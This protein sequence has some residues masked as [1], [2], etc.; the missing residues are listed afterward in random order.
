[1]EISCGVPHESVLGPLLYLIY[2]NDLGNATCRPNNMAKL[3]AD[4]TNSFV[5]GTSCYEVNQEAMYH[6]R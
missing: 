1:M 6:V 5:F 2:V 4:D 3:F